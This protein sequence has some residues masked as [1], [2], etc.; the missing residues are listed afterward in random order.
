MKYKIAVQGQDEEF[1]EVPR[2]KVGALITKL[3]DE[4]PTRLASVTVGDENIIF[5]LELDLPEIMDKVDLVHFSAIK[6][7]QIAAGR[8][9]G[10]MNKAKG[11]SYFSTISQ[12]RKIK[13]NEQLP[14]KRKKDITTEG[15]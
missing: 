6:S 10:N 1:N 2:C 5:P 3:R 9:T 13:N 14:I 8:R 12:K 7:K 11:S 4:D 15:C